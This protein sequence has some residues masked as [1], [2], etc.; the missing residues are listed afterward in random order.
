MSAR[1]GA[2]RHWLRPLRKGRVGLPAH[3]LGLAVGVGL[4]HLLPALPPRWPAIVLALLL[5]AMAGRRP[6]LAP[7]ALAA[8]GFAWA[9]HQACQV[10]CDPFPDGLSRASL[11]VTGRVA[12]LPTAADGAV[13]FLFRVESTR[14]GEAVADFKGLVRLSWY[15][16]APALR[17][18]ERWRLTV[19]LKPPHGFANPGGFDYERW[20][21]Q[22]G[23]RATG[24]VLAQHG[25]VRLDPGSGA[26]R[27]DRWRQ[28]L[29][30]HLDRVLAGEPGSALIQALVLGERTGISPVQWEVLT[31]TG[32]NHLIAISGLHVGLVAGL[33]FLLA[34]RAWAA[35]ARLALALAAPRAAAL[36]AFAAALIYSALAGFAVS[37]QRALIMLAVVL[38]AVGWARTLRPLAGISAAF[39]G[40][41]ILDPQ[42]VLSVGFWLSFGAV[43]VLLYAL[44][45]RLPGGGWW[46]RWGKA[47][48]A[49]GLGLLPLLFLTFG[50]ASLIAPAVNLIAVPLFSLVLLP[51]VLG[52]AVLSLVPGLGLPLVLMAQ[53]LDWGMSALEAVAGWS[54]S[55]AALSARPAWVWVAAFAGTFLLL[56]PRGL[57]GRSAGVVL[58]APLALVR[59]PLPPPGE[60]ELTLLDVGQGLAAVVRTQNHVLVY[61]TG[62]AFPSGFNTGSA[63]VLPFL[64]EIGARRIDTLILSH[65]DRD[66]VGGLPGLIGRIPI[67]ETL[68]GEPE[69]GSE[70]AAHACRAGQ[71]WTWDGVRFNLLH[72]GRAGLSG[73]NSS[74]VLRVATEGGSLL[75]TGDVDAR[76]ERQLAAQPERLR[77]TILVAG[78]H[79][80]SSSTS[81]VF[82][83]A[84]APDWVL[85]STGF[86]NHFGFPAA[87]VRERVRATGAGELDTAS[88]GAIGFTLGA[89]GVSGPSQFR[90]A[91]RRLWTHRPSGLAGPLPSP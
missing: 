44:G 1:I 23:I 74:C 54:W 24:H 82:L 10:L 56:A 50:R 33:V 63:V 86:G 29:R 87:A 20:L 59:P 60:A 72:P 61:D 41:V 47:Q 35:S 79:G 53:A 16:D 58:L 21:F 68:G 84:V 80:S 5:A 6:S 71:G 34:R 69:R 51:A 4:L 30:D 26:Y 11:E 31:R 45:Q 17:V 55:A 57:P 36:A 73:N 46:T 8:A 52:A 14:R 27:I 40:V 83:A 49:V 18:G 12:A 3:A 42:A 75:L 19:R 7:L 91:R 22:E 2:A 38:L 78:H 15:R 89:D 64:Q 81:A 66:H 32:T 13:R 9:Q 67:I 37:T 25:P 70:A 85:Y 62:P 65:G 39:I 76:V 48:W 77:S 88:S 43:A 28:D 90:E